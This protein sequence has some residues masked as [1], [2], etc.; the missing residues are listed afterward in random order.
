ME[1][2][3]PSNVPSLGS[4][5]TAE[6]Q[7]PV[8]A[9]SSR[10]AID[11][12]AESVVFLGGRRSETL[13][14]SRLGN[15]VSRRHLGNT[16]VQASLCP[17]LHQASTCPG[18]VSRW[19]ATSCPGIVSRQRVQACPGNVVSDVSGINVSRQRV[20]A[21]SRHRVRAACPGSI[22][23]R[24]VQGIVCPSQPRH[25]CPRHHRVRY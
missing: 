23:H 3:H 5:P 11:R 21:S 4:Q 13:H 10:R 22:Y 18:I 20:Q 15:R 8:T 25:T 9:R 2:P 14:Q 6:T 12:E 16:C 7:F 1:Y 19:R 17:T 24:C